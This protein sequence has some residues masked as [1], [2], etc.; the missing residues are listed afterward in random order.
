M[1]LNFYIEN[2]LKKLSLILKICII[3]I[4]LCNHLK[5]LLILIKS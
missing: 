2:Y 3:N 5:Q 4:L 1:Q